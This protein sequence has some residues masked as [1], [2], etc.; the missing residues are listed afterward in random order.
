MGAFP[1]MI[2]KLVHYRGRVQGVG[3]RYT[4]LGIARGYSV[5]GYVCNLPDGQV[6][7]WAEG[8]ADQVDLFL[9]AVQQQMADNI[10]EQHTGVQEPQGMSEFTIRSW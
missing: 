4:T 5:A 6:E 1:A 10:H 3:F 2:A 9:D 7:L 8:E